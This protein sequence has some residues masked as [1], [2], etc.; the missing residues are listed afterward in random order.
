LLGGGHRVGEVDE[1]GLAED[2]KGKAGKPQVDD[3]LDL[4]R[5]R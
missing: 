4:W 2:L 1:E 5:E 3:E